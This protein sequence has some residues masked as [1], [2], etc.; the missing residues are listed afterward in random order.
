[1]KFEADPG[2]L[3]PDCDAL[4]ASILWVMYECLESVDMQT[5]AVFVNLYGREVSLSASCQVTELSAE[6]LCK[7]SEILDSMSPDGYFFGMHPENDRT[8]GWWKSAHGEES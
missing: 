2:V 4:G 6:A 5:A 8:L 3:I 7:L 1:M